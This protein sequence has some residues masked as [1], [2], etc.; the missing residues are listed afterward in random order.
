MIEAL[1]AGGYKAVDLD[2]DEYSQWTDVDLSS[3]LTPE[4]GRDWVWRE[5]RVQQ[6]LSTEDTDILFV[7]GCAENMKLFRDQFDRVIL[8]SA[9]PEVIRERLARRNNNSFGKKPEHLAQVLTLQQTVEPLLRKFAGHE[10]DTRVPVS[11][12]VAQILFVAG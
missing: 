8:L 6:L 1:A 3:T 11:S 10:I 7:S 2:S 9:P 12:V 4:P 5:D